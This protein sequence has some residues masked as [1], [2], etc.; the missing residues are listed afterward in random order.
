RTTACRFVRHIA[1]IR[2]RII[3][4]LTGHPIAFWLNISLWLIPSPNRA[5]TGYKNPLPSCPEFCNA[6]ASQPKDPHLGRVIARTTRAT[7]P[8]G[9][10]IH[11]PPLCPV[12]FLFVCIGSAYIGR[13][14]L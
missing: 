10:G 4:Q 8:A 5:F 1:L 7:R 14:V 6:L 12:G 11:D 13:I 9:N 2:R 3:N